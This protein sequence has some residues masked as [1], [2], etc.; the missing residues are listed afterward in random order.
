M[1]VSLLLAV[2]LALPQAEFARYHEAITGRAP[3]EGALRLAID[4]S[5][6]KTGNDAYSIVSDGSRSPA[7]AVITGANLRSVFYGVYDLLERRGGCH[8]FW[9]G[10]VVPKKPS[11]DLSG[12]DVHEEA[13]FEWRG[14]R[15]FA[16][17]GLTRFQAEHWGLD[18]WKKEIDWCLKR[19]L[20]VV[21]PRIGQDDLFQRAFPDV[22]A[23]PD[24]ARDLPGHG[25]GYSNR[26]LFWSLEYRG[27]LRH[28]LQRYALDRGLEVPEDFGTMTHWYSPTPQDYLESRKPP[29]LPQAT[30][31]Y[32]RPDGLVW[33]IRDDKWADEYWKLTKTAVG[34]YNRP[35]PGLLHTIGLGERR[36]FTN[37]ADNL[38]LKIESL[39]KFLR[40]AHADYPDAKVL[41]GGWDFFYTW[42]PEEVQALVKTL[43]PVRDIVWDYEGDA[44]QDY[45]PELKGVGNNFTK[46]GVVGRFPY[47]YS[48]FL[49]YEEALDIRANYPLIEERQK[50]VQNDPFCRGFVFWPEASHTD[51]LLLRYFTAN[52]WRKGGVPHG[53]VL[54][55]FAASRYGDDAEVWRALWETVLPLSRLLD[56][57]GNYAKYVVNHDWYRD[58]EMRHGCK[59]ADASFWLAKRF[60]EPV[61]SAPAVFRGL[62]RLDWKKTAFT[63]RDAIDLA[64]TAA[65]RLLI[66]VNDD[67]VKA[68]HRWRYGLGGAEAV[69]E[70]GALLKELAVCMA[71]LLALHGDYSLAESFDRLNAVEPVANG[72]FPNVLMENALC[73]YSASHQYE[74]ARYWYAPAI[75]EYVDELVRRASAGDRS[76]PGGFGTFEGVRDRLPAGRPL[77]SMRPRS[78][79]T[80]QA[81]AEVLRRLADLA[82]AAVL[83]A[84][85]AEGRRAVC[86]AGARA[87]A[88]W[89]MPE[90][91]YAAPG[92]ECQVFFARMFESVKPS[93]YAFEAL[94]EK[95]NFWEDR[96]SWTPGAAD[97]GS[98][99][100]VVFRALTDDGLV[101]CA[102]TTVVVAKAPT[103]A[104]KSRRTTLALFSASSTNCRYQDR[105]R[106]RMREAGFAGYTPVGSHTGTSS[107]ME[108]DPE[109]GAPHDGYGGF[110]WGD[111]TTRWTMSVDEIDNLQAEAERE[112][113][114][115]FGYKIPEGQEWRRGLLKSPLVKVENGEKVVDVQRW[116]DKVNG[117][118]P[119]DYI[120][121][122]LGG[123]GVSTI[124]ADRIE[125]AVA[126]QLVSAERLLGHLRKACPKT[127]I[128]IA[129]AFGG[130]IEQAGWGKNYGATISAFQGNINRIKYD[131]AI[132]R[133][134]ETRGDDNIVFVPFSHGVDPVRA[135]PRTEED[136]NALHGTRLSGYQ[137][138]DAL[139]AWLLND[140]TNR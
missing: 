135:Y 48:V 8:W 31:D 112:Q 59:Y 1:N 118:E 90:T 109:K 34:A 94:S 40:R 66:A 122:V 116:L 71:D 57:N 86:A 130:S 60:P 138:G 2:S 22:C 95:G 3:E 97:A 93:N 43:D 4:P 7:R 23:Y 70:K 28:D 75:A 26:T 89:F 35:D 119:P 131:R 87:K 139:F 85:R 13:Q 72:N 6:S 58:P 24:P 110:A 65:D 17:R 81:Y 68:F 107:S 30:S 51:T 50:I 115:K 38:A 120:L 14:I 39:Q 124:P 92:V 20:N 121:I 127:R 98:R 123:N 10:D 100:R 37:R 111:F 18:D 137:A 36:C 9:D 91:L 126:R 79:Q 74:A 49:A 61:R 96:W 80:R 55:E 102:T 106:A 140:I 114:R 73:A 128:A 84:D 129:Q 45:R 19:R 99:V 12:L 136:G 47:T 52:A 41:L 27:R 108:C 105:L 42:H 29:F 56:W 62:S 67:M 11:L 83:S 33:D 77:D 69:A 5:V 63:E 25:R 88:R 103:A 21:M 132:K 44:T 134:V 117:G 15:Y 53:D 64:R 125:T 16:H 82:E 32:S 78:P 54:R 104:E 76:V 133:F 46:W 113:L 101:D